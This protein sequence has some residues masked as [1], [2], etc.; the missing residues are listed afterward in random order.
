MNAI[1]LI[2]AFAFSAAAGYRTLVYQGNRHARQAIADAAR[3]SRI[4][5]GGASALVDRA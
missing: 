3:E 4:T 2:H 5:V 1:R